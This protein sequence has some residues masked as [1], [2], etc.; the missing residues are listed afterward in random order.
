MVLTLLSQ[1]HVSE[2]FGSSFIHLKI[3]GI[4]Y[5]AFGPPHI[6]REGIADVSTLQRANQTFSAKAEEGSSF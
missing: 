4:S 6:F 3:G 1:G 5:I 2:R